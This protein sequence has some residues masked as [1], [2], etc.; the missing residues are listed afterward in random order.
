MLGWSCSIHTTRSNLP[1]ESARSVT[2]SEKQQLRNTISVRKFQI[3]E[4]FWTSFQEVPRILEIFWSGTWKYRHHCHSHRNF[5][6]FCIPCPG[7]STTSKGTVPWNGKLSEHAFVSSR[8]FSHPSLRTKTRYPNHK[9]RLVTKRTQAKQFHILSGLPSAVIF[10]HHSPCSFWHRRRT[11]NL[12]EFRV[13]CLNCWED[14]RP[15][16]VCHQPWCR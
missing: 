13:V 6:K 12:P 7:T 9:Q 2:H 16:I 14:T 10:S 3:L 1:R 4:L 8:A 15:K 11:V 5:R